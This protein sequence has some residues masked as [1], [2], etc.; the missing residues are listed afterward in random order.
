MPV[1]PEVWDELVALIAVRGPKRTRASRP[2]SELEQA[3][4]PIV[5]AI[6]RDVG[7]PYIDMPE[8]QFWPIFRAWLDA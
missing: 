1:D 3:Q 8:D 2:L 7:G 4:L 5:E 6:L